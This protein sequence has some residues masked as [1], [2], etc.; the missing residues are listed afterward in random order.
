MRAI[1]WQRALGKRLL[2][3]GERNMWN[4]SVGSTSRTEYGSLS[5]VP[6]LKHNHVAGIRNQEALI[7][8]LC[9]LC[10][11]RPENVLRGRESLLLLS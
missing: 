5:T 3:K 4:E 9:P 11:Y 1:R 7:I 2:N 8:G 6:L 10:Y